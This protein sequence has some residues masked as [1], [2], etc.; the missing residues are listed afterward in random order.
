MTVL[1]GLVFMGSTVAVSL[2][3]QD[4]FLGELAD[5]MGDRSHAPNT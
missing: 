4:Y 5:P 1:I 3:V 2:V